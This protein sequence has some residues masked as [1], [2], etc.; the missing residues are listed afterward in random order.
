MLKELEI[1]DFALIRKLRVPFTSGLNVL[2]GETGAGKSIIID[3]LNAVLGGKVGASIIRQG[4]AR[5]VIEASFE[6]SAEVIAWLKQNE[7]Y[8]ESFEGMIVSREISKSGTKARINGT[9]VNIST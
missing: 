5:A 9:L 3:A 8:D 6:P 7:L 2:T 1:R 4:C